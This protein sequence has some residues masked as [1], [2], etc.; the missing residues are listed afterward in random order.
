MTDGMNMTE[1]EAQKIVEDGKHLILHDR[2]DIGGFSVAFARGVLH[3]LSLGRKEAE[4]LV[5]ALEYCAVEPGLLPAAS[6]R[7]CAVAN[8]VLAAYKERQNG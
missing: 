4:P 7:Q 5:K 1:A 8:N 2:P 6:N 3:G